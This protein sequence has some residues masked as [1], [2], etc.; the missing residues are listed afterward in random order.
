[1]T[2][3]LPTRTVH[4]KVVH[5][6]RKDYLCSECKHQIQ[7]GE[8]YT[9]IRVEVKSSLHH[10]YVH[11][12]CFSLLRRMAAFNERRHE[13]ELPQ[14]YIHQLTFGDLDVRVANTSTVHPH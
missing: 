13:A 11:N 14:T 6:S 5:E 7:R 12:T 10:F 4:K 1:M 9:Q 3:G 2:Y 8:S